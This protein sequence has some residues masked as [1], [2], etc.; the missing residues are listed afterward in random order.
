MK[1]QVC[2]FLAFIISLPNIAFSQKYNPAHSQLKY[3]EIQRISVKEAYSKY[4][5]NRGNVV[6]VDAMNPKTYATYHVLGAI[7]VST[8]GPENLKRLR[9]MRLPYPKTT[10]FLFY[11]D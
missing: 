10:E 11:C 7:N 1:S 2:I 8:D 6:F 4:K 9:T 5:Y 3:P